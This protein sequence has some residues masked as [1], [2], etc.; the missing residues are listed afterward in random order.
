LQSKVELVHRFCGREFGYLLVKVQG[1]THCYLHCSEEFAYLVS[2]VMA[3]WDII[4]NFL[5]GE[6]SLLPPGIRFHPT[7]VELLLYYLK[8]KVMGKRLRFEAIPEVDI[9]KFP[10]SVLP[11]TWE[12]SYICSFVYMISILCFFCVILTKMRFF[13]RQRNLFWEV[14]I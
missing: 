10:P 2:E 3:L 12:D 14:G 11:G 8:K 7:D 5:M 13:L 1:I 4:L 9:Y 6:R